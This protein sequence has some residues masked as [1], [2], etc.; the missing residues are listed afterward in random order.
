ML[1]VCLHSSSGQIVRAR[2]RRSSVAHCPITSTCCAASQG[3]LT[4]Q[5]CQEAPNI[6]RRHLLSALIAAGGLLLPLRPSVAEQPDV[7]AKTPSVTEPPFDAEAVATASSVAQDVDA[8]AQPDIPGP[9]QSA[10]EVADSPQTSTSG[11]ANPSTPKLVSLP[12]RTN[13]LVIISGTSPTTLPPFI[14]QGFP[15]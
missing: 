5:P 4:T 1:G 3:A 10:S 8:A 15:A 7:S 13:T 2:A 12:L 14:P 6:Y 11:S 9:L